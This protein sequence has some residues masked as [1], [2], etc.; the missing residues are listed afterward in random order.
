[1][2]TSRHWAAV[3]L[4]TLAIGGAAPFADAASP[5]PALDLTAAVVVAPD[6]AGPE[7]AA[8]DMLVDEVSKRTGVSWP[9]VPAAGQAK[10]RIVIT[11]A[12]GAKKPEGYSLRTERRGNQATLVI[13]GNDHRG[14]LFGI[15]HV[16]RTLAMA[17]GRVVLDQPL[18]LS[19]SP[20]QAERGHQIGYRFKNNTYDAWTLAQFEQQIRDL[21]VFGAN[22][23]QLIA[24][25]SDDEPTSPLFPAPA[26]D[27]VLGIAQL[28]DKYGL[29]CDLYYPEMRKDY[30]DPATVAAELAAFE[31]LVKRFPHIHALYVPG[32]DPGH[33]PPNLL[34]PL[35]E[36]QANILRRYHPGAQLWVSAQGFDQAFYEDFY[37]LLSRRP[38]W[39]TGVFFGPQSRDPLPVQ[40]AR[41][42]RR[43]PIQFYPDI[44]HTL[45]AQFPVPEFDPVF[46]LLEGREPINPRP[47]DQTLIFNR[48]AGL[49]TGFMTYSEGVNDDVNKVLWTR[50]GW[51]PATRPEETLRDYARYF[52]GGGP[53]DRLA[54]LIPA[55]ER[56]WTGPIAENTGINATLQGFQALATEP[57][58]KDNWRFESLLYRATYDAYARAR[59]GAEAGRQTDAMAALTQAPV[60]GSHDA[61]AAATAALSQPDDAETARLRDQL[62]D[63][64]HRLWTHVGLQLSV[65]LY[66]ASGIE[67]G[68]N[69]DRV[70]TSLNDRVWLTRRFA[71]IARQPDEAT[72]QRDLADIVAWTQPAPGTLYDDLGDPRRE[73]HLVRGAGFDR[74]PELYASAIDGIAD[75][76]PDDGWRLSWITYAET[77]YERPIHL[78]YRHLDPGRRYTLRVTYAGEDYALPMRL[79]AGTGVEIHAALPRPNNPATL[80]F[81]IPVGAIRDGQLDLEWTRPPGLGGSG[82]GHQ[83]A[84][85]WLI[86]QP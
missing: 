72:R 73:P 36:R 45:H 86:P 38:A 30:A 25:D 71:D 20:A 57:A 47:R 64:A 56:N 83:V 12:T 52:M 65:P 37:R 69:L 55:L 35:L 54:A 16:L 17:P 6:A 68:A 19:T 49:T 8:V 80:E 66:G 26:L 11:H 9:L 41:I 53:D 46:A 50:L 81:N 61:M 3:L 40:R 22:A 84:E 27:T 34:F 79:K 70:D 29:D 58:L 44:G 1:M 43:Y 21:A 74:D 31:D 28:L 15:G 23:I 7:K 13:A 85:A 62:F 18:N 78:R 77:L 60:Q 5:L 51:S 39:L 67:R 10:V 4:A 76:T 2:P 42:P 63:L 75:R 24:P 59:A 14:V 82:R 48:L 33:T 32:G